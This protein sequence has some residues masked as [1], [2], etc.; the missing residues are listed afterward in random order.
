LESRAAVL[1]AEAAKELGEHLADDKE[2]VWTLSVAT[3]DEKPVVRLA[4]VERRGLARLA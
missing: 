3:N 1:R 2:S 4:V